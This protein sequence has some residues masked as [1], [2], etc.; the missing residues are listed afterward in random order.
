MVWMKKQGPAA[1]V[2]AVMAAVGFLYLALYWTGAAAQADMPGG[3]RRFQL[4]L[5]EPATGIARGQHAIHDTLLWVSV[6][7]CVV[8]FGAMFY[9]IFMH[10][11]SRGAKAADFHESTAVEI[12]WTI[13]PFVIVVGL[14]VAATHEVIAQKDTSN[15]H[16][17]VK[18]T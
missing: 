3:P 7:I 8:V 15:A 1:M 5:P 13:V 12:A 6:A 14:A 2:R 10:R 4:N 16:L 18:A 11:K 17:T 9:A